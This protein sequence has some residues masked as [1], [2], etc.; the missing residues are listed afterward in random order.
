MKTRPARSDRSI[1]AGATTFPRRDL[2][3]EIERLTAPQWRRV[4]A[5]LHAGVV[6][7]ESPSGGELER[8]LRVGSL[9]R[10]IVL[11]DGERRGRPFA[12]LLPQAAVQEQLTG[13]LLIVARPLQPA[14]LLEPFVCHPLEDRRQ[15]TQLVP[16]RLGG[17]VAP[18]V[19][20]PLGDLADDPDIVPRVAGG[21]EGRAQP[22]H[23]PLAVRDRALG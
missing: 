5:G 13:V 23:A 18:V 3:R 7:I 22:L 14:L 20:E 11:H 19:P 16:D 10:R 9:E 1:W 8:I 2:G 15:L 21:R 17:R 4:P 12:R 6:R